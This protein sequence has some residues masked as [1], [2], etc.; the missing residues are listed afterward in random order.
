MEYFAKAQLYFAMV[1]HALREDT[2]KADLFELVFSITC[3]RTDITIEVSGYNEIIPVILEKALLIMRELQVEPR[4]FEVVK[5]DERKGLQNFAF[6][7]PYKQAQWKARW[8]CEEGHLIEPC[9]TKVSRLTVADIQGFFADLTGQANIEILAQGNMY[10]QDVLEVSGLV[11][12][13][14]KPKPLPQS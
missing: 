12:A 8:L 11:E 13:T 3:S 4:R 14:F 6:I 5:A 2:Y 9:A 7:E 1:K 10:K